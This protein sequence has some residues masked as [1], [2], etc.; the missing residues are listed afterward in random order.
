MLSLS[1]LI[2]TTH[3]VDKKGKQSVGLT[4]REEISWEP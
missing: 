3:D 4:E 2:A 1:N